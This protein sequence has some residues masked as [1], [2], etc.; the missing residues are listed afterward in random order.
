MNNIINP[1][2][3]EGANNLPDNDIIG[4]YIEDYNFSRFIQST[5]NIF[6]IGERGSGK[7]MTLLYN[8]FK[9]QYKIANQKSKSISFD[10]I[11]IHVPCNTPLFHK[12]EYLLLNDDFKKSIICE[13]YL[14]LSILYAIAD[15]L[16]E[17]PEII[18]SSQSQKLDFFSEIEY[19]W[20]V[21]LDHSSI[22]FF[23]SIKR[24][25]NKE[26]IATQKKI[27][28]Y[29]SDAFYENALSFSS[30]IMPFFTLIRKISLVQSSH[31]LIMIDDAHDMNKYQIQTLNSWIAYRDHS[32]FSFKVATAKVNR[33]VFIT[34]TGGSILEGHDFITVDME[35]AYQNEETDFFKLA[36]KI[37]ERRLENIGLKGVTAE[38]FFPVNESFSK[39]IEKYKAI[40]KQQ[41]EEK[42]GTNATKSVQ[43][44][45]YKYHRAMYF[46]ERSAKANKPPYSGFETIVDISTGIV[47]N[48]LDPCYWMFDNALNNNKDGI[49]QISPKIQTQIIVER[50]QRMWDVLRNG[51]DKIIDN[52]T[53]EQGKQIFQLFENLM[54]LFSKRLVSDISE[55]RAIVFSIS[56]KDTHPELYKEIIALIDL[57]RK[58]QFIYTRIGNAKD[59]GKQE[60]YYVPNRLLFPSLGLDPHGQYSRVSLK[61]S[62]IW[63]AAVNN[64]QFPINEETSTSINLQKNLFDE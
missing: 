28:T 15:T 6:L 10:K 33:P 62:D 34:S 39:D 55:P 4:Y 42:Y 53:I 49:T 21:D 27:N 17:I 16:S 43:D 1:F 64:K 18:E 47:R 2:E 3:Y 14:V 5:K 12:K 61:V 29:N 22:N 44:Y 40:A 41:A 58:V 46:R 32:I 7:T 51:L 26:M 8:S 13:H 9:I 25:V 30:S 36:K 45:I 38:E 63:N 57:A 48:L 31:F 37:I 60:I 56:Q 35:R 11:G 23:E 24:Y 50:S 19:I 52:C 59:K 20:G 54:I